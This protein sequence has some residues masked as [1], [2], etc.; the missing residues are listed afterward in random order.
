MYKFILTFCDI[1]LPHI[2]YFIRKCLDHCVFSHFST[3]YKLAVMLITNKNI[4]N[5]E[6]I[7]GHFTLIILLVLAMR[8]DISP[9]VPVTVNNPYSKSLGTL[10]YAVAN[11]AHSNNA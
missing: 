5:F 6:T 4:F 3:Y 11:T 10:S 2:S 8:K 9:S 1:F 7:F